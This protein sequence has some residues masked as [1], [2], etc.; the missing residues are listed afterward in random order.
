MEIAKKIPSLK[1]LKNKLRRIFNDFIRMRD[2]AHG[3]IS[4]GKRYTWGA[5]WQAGHYFPSS[6]CNVSLDFDEL[7]VNGQCAHCNMND[8]NKQGYIRGLIR[9]YG[10]GVLDKLDVKRA[11]SRKVRW[12]IFEY[13]AMIVHYKTKLEKLGLPAKSS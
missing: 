3:C 2:L 11:T 7:N 8:G 10:A 4:C 6:V 9:R 13:Q 1:S 5:G 12:G